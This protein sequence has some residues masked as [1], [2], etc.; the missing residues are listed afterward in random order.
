MLKRHIYIYF[1]ERLL[2]FKQATHLQPGA[3]EVGD[4]AHH[5]RVLKV[6]LLPQTRKSGGITVTLVVCGK[7]GGARTHSGAKRTCYLRLG[8]CIGACEMTPVTAYD[9]CMR[10]TT[11]LYESV[12]WASF[13][14]RFRQHTV[15]RNFMPELPFFIGEP[16]TNDSTQN[17]LHRESI[18]SG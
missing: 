10:N 3:T 6:V 12:I 1:R 16:C 14:Q 11:S 18:S 9:G 4:A 5:E 2:G 17:V 13:L 15:Q 7:G 8:S